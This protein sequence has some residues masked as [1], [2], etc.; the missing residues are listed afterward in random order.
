MLVSI[1]VRGKGK[2]E[3]RLW[4]ELIDWLECLRWL[5]HDSVND[6]CKKCVCRAQKENGGYDCMKERRIVRNARDFGIQ[7][8]G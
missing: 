4:E 8:R 3:E 2:G 7:T 5:W 1:F 6:F